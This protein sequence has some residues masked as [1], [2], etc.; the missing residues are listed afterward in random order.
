MKLPQSVADGA[1]RV[2]F[3]RYSTKE[4]VERLVEVLKAAAQSLAKT[5]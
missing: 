3:S 5:K 2:S 4:E 1:I